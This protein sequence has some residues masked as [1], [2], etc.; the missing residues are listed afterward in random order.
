[1]ENILY[2]WLFTYNTITSTWFA[3]HRDDSRGYWNGD[4]SNKRTIYKDEEFNA[5]LEKVKDGERN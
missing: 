4:G 3:Y 5:L 2:G 1:M